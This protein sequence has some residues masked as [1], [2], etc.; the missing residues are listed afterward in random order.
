VPEQPNPYI[1]PRGFQYNERLFGREKELR[2]LEGQL[3]ADRIVLLHAPS[4]AGKTSLINAGLL[5]MMRMEDFNVLPVARMNFQPPEDER[6]NRYV[7]SA[8]LCMEEDRARET[9]LTL[10]QLAGLELDEYLKQRSR[11][12]DTPPSDLLVFD[13]FEEVLELDPTD[14]DAKL[15][16]FTQLGLALRNLNRY[17][18]FAMREDYLGALDPYRRFIPGRLASTYRLDLLGPEA[19]LQAVRGPIQ[20]LGMEI[21]EEAV[22]RLVD[23]LRSVQVQQPDGSMALALGQQ[24]EPVQLQVVMQR[25]WEALPIGKQTINLEDVQ[26]AGDVD[27]SLANF[28]TEVIQEVTQRTGIAELDIRQWF[29]R[30]LISAAGTR[31][32]IIMERGSSGGLDNQAIFLLEKARLIRAEKRGG[33]TFYELVHDRMIEPV[34]VN[35]QA[36]FAANVNLFQRRAAQWEEAGRSEALLLRGHELAAAYEQAR[37]ILSTPVEMEYL[38]A[39]RRASQAAARQRRRQ[40]MLSILLAVSLLLNLVLGG[41]LLFGAGGFPWGVR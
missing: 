11:D 20:S 12:A 28:Y 10:D 40:F 32:Q 1:G 18:L 34:R 17:A 9:R 2:Q 29:D 26:S 21:D 6:V 24:V 8:L 5:P 27:T 33:A 25:I 31:S 15:Q 23:D 19:A 36:W 22:R 35:N 3:L 14:M 4:G 37:G 41:L 39:S 16:F 7:Y 38:E 13:Q 30:R